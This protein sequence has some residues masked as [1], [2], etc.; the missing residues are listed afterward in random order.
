MWP[1][2]SSLLHWSL[3]SAVFQGHSLQERQ[4]LSKIGP[5]CTTMTRF[6]VS[7]H[8]REGPKNFTIHTKTSKLVMG[9]KWLQEA[10][11]EKEGRQGMHT[12]QSAHQ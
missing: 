2:K 9:T 3:N 5:I 8:E 10:A 7:T 1:L 6:A 12:S 4:T 11:R